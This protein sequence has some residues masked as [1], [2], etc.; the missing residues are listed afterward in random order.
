MHNAI[1]AKV[2]EGGA[3]DAPPQKDPRNQNSE[4]IV[5]KCYSAQIY[6]NFC[7]HDF[8]LQAIL[9]LDTAL[10]THCTLFEKNTGSTVTAIKNQNCLYEKVV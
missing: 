8:F 6:F 5:T 10:S 9:I 4:N 2:N 3:S 1:I 7:I